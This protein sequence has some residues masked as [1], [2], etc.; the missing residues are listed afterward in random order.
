MTTAVSRR[1]V[2]ALGAGL[3]ASTVLG[4]HALA[5]AAKLGTQT[6]YWHR[7]VV[8][9]AEVTV[10]SDGPLP[11]GPPKGTFVGV[12]DEEVRKMLSD[13][14]LDPDNVVLEQNSPVVNNGDKLILFDPGMAT[15]KAF[16]PTTARPEK[17]MAGAAITPSDVD[18]VGRSDAPIGRDRGLLGGHRKTRF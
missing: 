15:S 11:L 12:P 14:F 5:K 10:V 18:G 6:P 7:F 8:G 4:G 17:S 2:L 16:R 13:N 1:S 9:D 3:G